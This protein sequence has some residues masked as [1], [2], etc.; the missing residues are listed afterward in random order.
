MR[1]PGTGTWSGSLSTGVSTCFDEAH[2]LEVLPGY[3]IPG[4]RP[5]PRTCE[6]TCPAFRST[7]F[8]AAIKGDAG[9]HSDFINAVPL[10]EEPKERKR[11]PCPPCS[12]GWPWPHKNVVEPRER[13]RSRP[14]QRG[15]DQVASE[16]MD[17]RLTSCA[18]VEKRLAGMTTAEWIA[19]L[20][21]G[22][23]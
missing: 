5:W 16:S 6:S 13:N 22:H 4:L 14:R 21:G 20:A 17:S 1:K 15:S 12:I 7:L 3:A 9:S 2:R 10:F 19:V 11:K 18:A 23:D 8:S